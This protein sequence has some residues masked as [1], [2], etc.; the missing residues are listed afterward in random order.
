MVRHIILLYCKTRTEYRYMPYC[1]I[2][3]EHATGSQIHGCHHGC[4][5]VHVD[6]DQL[7]QNVAIPY[8]QYDSSV[9]VY[10]LEY[11]YR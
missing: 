5:R 11:R 2:M 9:Y 3:A 6:A 4:T 10:V 7:M 8:A 1:N